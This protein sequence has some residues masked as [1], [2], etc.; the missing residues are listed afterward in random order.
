MSGKDD[1][2]IQ[3]G[4]PGTPRL[5]GVGADVRRPVLA[6]RQAVDALWWPSGWLGE[7]ARRQAIL[8]QW[9]DGA[10]LH[11]FDDGDLLCWP[12]ST[13]MD[14]GELG[15]WPLRRVD[16][17]LSSA[18]VDRDEWARRTDRAGVDA[19]LGEGGRLR[20]LRFADARRGD[21]SE[22]LDAETLLIEP[23]DLTQPV[24]EA[25]LVVAPRDLREVLGP[26][27]P[28]ETAAA[29]REMLDALRRAGER[30]RDAGGRAK[31]GAAHARDGASGSSHGSGG[32]FRWSWFI[33]FLLVI[34]AL[35]ILALTS[36]RGPESG[37]DGGSWL[38]LLVI[39]A[40]V[41]MF[42][43]MAGPRRGSDVGSPGGS[44]AQSVPNNAPTGASGGGVVTLLTVAV[45]RVVDGA[46]RVAGRVFGQR[47]E[48]HGRG[49]GDGDG[50]AAGG[51]GKKDPGADGLRARLNRAGIRPQAWRNWAARLS[52]T[53][54]L[55]SM[56]GM[57]NAAYMRR[58]M[59]MFDD[60]D[61]KDALRHAPPVSGSGAD[62]STGPAFFL[63]P[64]QDL[65]LQTRVGGGPSFGASD[66]LMG[67]LRALYRNTAA[68]LEAQGRIDEAA[69]VL[70]VLLDDKQGA[71]DLMERHGRLDKAAEL[72]LSW[73]MPAAT[74]VRYYALA[75]DWR[76]AV[77]VARRD[78]AFA[79]AVV[80][81]EKRW[82]DVARRLRVEWAE[83][84][85]ERGEPRAAIRTLWPVAEERER[86]A[87]WLASVE[88]AGGAEAA[89]AL[90]WR[91]LGWPD[92]L[93]LHHEAIDRLISSPESAVERAAL[94]DE[95]LSLSGPETGAV[96][97][98]ALLLAGPVLEDQARLP[99]PLL[100]LDHLK[101]LTKLSGDAALAADLPEWKKSAMDRPAQSLGQRET[102][103]D[104]TTPP[105]TGVVVHDAMPLPDGEWLVALGESGVVR[106]DARGRRRAHLPVPAQR[107]VAAFDGGSALLLAARELNHWRVSRLLIPQERVIELGVHRFAAFADR[108]DGEAWT[109]SDGPRV[110]VLDVR[111]PLLGEVLWQVAD[112][113]GTPVA[114][115]AQ[116]TLEHWWLA[117]SR[118]KQE[119]WMYAV[120]SRRL[121][122]RETLAAPGDGASRR[123]DSP[124]AFRHAQN[125][126]GPID[127][128]PFIDG[129]GMSCLQPLDPMHPAKPFPTLLAEDGRQVLAV[130][131]RV[132]AM[133]VGDPS[134]PR[135]E[136]LGLESGRLLARWPWPSMDA[137]MA[138][139]RG[140]MWMLFDEE[141]RAVALDIENGRQ[142]RLSATGQG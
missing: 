124:S 75:G 64:R 116:P 69:Y 60:G 44:G 112:L 11:R 99:D 125:D 14:C 35:R 127:F 89:R 52:M 51:R 120:P 56:I 29:T 115:S 43:L 109:T 97:H 78:R 38:V 74:I 6:G 23:F 92:S 73:D 134:G 8:V 54:G 131:G 105:A 48:G 47:G 37:F 42:V 3:D 12:V 137:P 129:H 118:D 142:W 36:E 70:A 1:V 80:A 66:Q 61:L 4:A 91:A 96:R 49:V 68:K 46:G 79:D 128:Q 55:M 10:T 65:S 104:L 15:A 34:S 2:T 121:L 25:E 140:G 40:L 101:R 90:A 126:D 72:A 110:R 106:L 119:Q 81:L 83:S 88:A 103:V 63:G 138:R 62:P 123:P 95:L 39:L 59:R 113:P 133:W 24:P 100:S 41:I 9:R 86:A 19:W 76:Q 132:V 98:L 30:S 31:P 71:L 114:I 94:A 139:F 58:V 77:R 13:W 136:L 22:W 82:P 18:A 17:V 117:T 20:P 57:R 93:A 33:K 141:G 111:A 85:A 27:V 53:T 122:R 5:P 87:G 130:G 28:A 108:F 84:L 26:D 135:V 16:G 102:P 107:L 45:A 21:P 67:H 7:G 32:A 50:S